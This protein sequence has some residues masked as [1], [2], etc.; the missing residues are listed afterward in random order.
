MVSTSRE[1]VINKKQCFFFWTGKCVSKSLTK[2]L[3][4]KY[5]RKWKKMVKKRVRRNQVFL[6]FGNNS[7][8]KEH[9]RNSRH[10]FVDIGK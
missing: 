2:E 4:E 10:P 5:L 1:K 7:R 6:I 9:E 3:L 8:S